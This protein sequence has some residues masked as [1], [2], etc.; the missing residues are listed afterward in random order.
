[1]Q[2]HELLFWILFNL[3]VAAMLALD[4]GVL[5][6]KAHIIRFREALGWS[7]VWVSLAACFAVGVYFWLGRTV[8]LEFTTGYLVE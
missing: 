8:A 1:M 7:A 2:S 5:N 6:R 3:F 4:L